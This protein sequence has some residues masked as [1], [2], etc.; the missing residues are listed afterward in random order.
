M[1]FLRLERFFGECLSKLD[2]SSH[3]ALSPPHGALEQNDFP[4]RGRTI[5]VEAPFLELPFILPF[6]VFMSAAQLASRY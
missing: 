1:L 2:H 6:S 3:L 4:V 5:F